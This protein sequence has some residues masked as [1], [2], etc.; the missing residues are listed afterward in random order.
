MDT[1]TGEIKPMDELT[2]EQLLSGKWVELG[3]RPNPGCRRC[4]GR[5]YTGRNLTTG[6]VIQC[7]CVK[8]RP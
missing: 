1:S 7:R 2:P 6:N 8:E 3:Q 5:G 4:H